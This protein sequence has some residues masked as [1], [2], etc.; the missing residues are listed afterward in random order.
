[1]K[2][3]RPS[4][5]LFKAMQVAIYKILSEEG[6]IPKEKVKSHTATVINEYLK[7]H[8]FPNLADLNP[9]DIDNALHSS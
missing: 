8:G 2:K 9:K 3:N 6:N 5:L 1:F 7:T 4:K